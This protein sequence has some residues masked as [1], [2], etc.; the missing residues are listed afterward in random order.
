MAPA[1]S[2]RRCARRRHTR[3]AAGT[4]GRGRTGGCDEDRLTWQADEGS[5]ETAAS[6]PYARG[7]RQPT[8]QCDWGAESVAVTTGAEVVTA[9]VSGHLHKNR[10]RPEPLEGMRPGRPSGAAGRCRRRGRGRA[11]PA[12]LAHARAPSRGEGWNLTTEARGRGTRLGLPLQRTQ[13]WRQEG[14]GVGVVAHSARWDEGRSG[15]RQGRT[16]GRGWSGSS[17]MKRH[18]PASGRGRERVTATWRPAMPLSGW[19]CQLAVRLIRE[20]RLLRQVGPMKQ[21]PGWTAWGQMGQNSPGS[22]SHGRCDGRFHVSTWPGCGA[23]RLRSAHPGVAV[24]GY[25]CL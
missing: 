24:A 3:T 2:R 17:S 22:R 9:R 16:Q 18:L 5:P 4:R 7:T 10:P 14:E 19:G 6:G 25:R 23:D 15:R 20:G 8:W 11:Q 13:S 21:D 1:A 12:T